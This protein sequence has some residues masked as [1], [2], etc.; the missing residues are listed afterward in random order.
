MGSVT[1]FYG[2]GNYRKERSA[3]LR[4]GCLWSCQAEPSCLSLAPQ[5]QTQGYPGPVIGSYERVEGVLPGHRRGRWAE[6]WVPVP[7]L[8]AT[9]LPTADP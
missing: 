5:P 4:P 7:A 9:C 3:G 2:G 1:H 6:L 8:P